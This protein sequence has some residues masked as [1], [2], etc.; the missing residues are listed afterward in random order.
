MPTKLDIRYS[1]KTEVKLLICYQIYQK[2]MNIVPQNIDTQRRRVFKGKNWKRGNS[3]DDFFL[4]WW[5]FLWEGE[6][7]VFWNNPR[8]MQQKSCTHLQNGSMQP[9]ICCTAPNL[10]TQICDFGF[11]TLVKAVQKSLLNA[12]PTLHS[13]NLL[14]RKRESIV[15]KNRLWYTG[16]SFFFTAPDPI[17][18]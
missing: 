7:G 13:R 15:K 8:K 12:R 2:L 1:P 6:F 4:N 11:A 5:A 18:K 14:C 9:W 10:E 17:F 3:V 16:S